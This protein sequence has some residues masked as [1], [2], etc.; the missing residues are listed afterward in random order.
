MQNWDVILTTMRVLTL[1]GPYNFL[2]YICGHSKVAI[3]EK[4][5][6]VILLAMGLLTPLYLTR[7]ISM[8]SNDRLLTER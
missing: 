7:V 3:Y 1:S 8:S 6:F 4:Q 5:G 2:R